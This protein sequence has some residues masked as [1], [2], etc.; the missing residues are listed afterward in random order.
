MENHKGLLG[1]SGSFVLLF[2][3]LGLATAPAWAQ[4]TIDTS[5]INANNN[6][7]WTTPS[8]WSCNCVPNN[9][10]TNVFNVFDS[11]GEPVLDN[12]S[13]TTSITVESLT[14]DSR[15]AGLAILDGETL[16][17]TGN[18]NSPNSVIFVVGG[19][20]LNVG[21][22]MESGPNLTID[23]GPTVA[24]KVTV[25]G[26]F[27]GGLVSM[28]G[29]AVAEGQTLL[30][31]S[32]AAPST[33]TGTYDFGGGSAAVEYGSGGITQIGTGGPG[34]SGGGSIA[35][36]GPNSY[37]E[38]STAPGSNS[39]LAGLKTIASNGGLGLQDG[40]SL[41][42]TG[43]LTNNGSIGLYSGAPGPETLLNVAGAAPG[44]LTGSFGV[45]ETAGEAA[46]EYSSGGITQIG[47][48]TSQGG[49][50]DLDGSTAYVEIGATN[51][52]SAL[53]NLKTVAANGSLTLQGSASVSTAASLT[54]DGTIKMVGS[55]LSVGA[56]I[57]NS[58]TILMYDGTLTALSVKITGGTL[59]G[60]GTVNGNVVNDAIVSLADPAT[61]TINGSYTQKDD[62]A[63][64]IQIGSATA[65]SI[66]DVNGEASLGGTVDFN[67][68]NGYAPGANTDLAFLEAGSVTGDFSAVEFT[69][70][71]CPTCTF[72]LS[73]L[74]LDTGSIPPTSTPEP[75]TLILFGTGLLALAT[76][77]RRRRRLVISGS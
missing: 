70:I 3:A 60:S 14:L 55:T 76:L 36:I 56:G 69:G 31:V 50:L 74:S 33:L 26:T 22:N 6:G 17:V 51:S 72:N 63:L 42:T 64:V 71:N 25:G 2:I 21:G 46:L 40:A 20:T 62:G 48:G 10:S 53:T 39:A 18:L 24:S 47:D 23:T 7:N 28:Y 9:S 52:N 16:N 41:S 43:A 4:T 73:T 37:M 58:G 12:T 15:Q 59:Y 19:S 34:A 66:L 75:G 29:G 8:N 38:L 1:V 27:T 32:G 44:T 68:L 5:L 77:L 49:S 35:L 57:T 61:L 11:T 13:S 30:S 54:N 67:F 45:G 65:Y